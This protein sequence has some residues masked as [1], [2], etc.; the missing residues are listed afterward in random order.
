MKTTADNPFGWIQS[1][2]FLV[3]TLVAA[4]SASSVTLYRI[5]SLEEKVD[6]LVTALDTINIMKYEL[7]N[8]KSH[9]V[10]ASMIFEKFSD[11][12]DRLAITVSKL[13]GKVELLE[14]QDGKK[15]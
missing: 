1:N 14:R 4:I 13:D 10:Q 6:S 8:I 2:H 7:E 5:N 11:S 12:V 15:R 3:A 9:N